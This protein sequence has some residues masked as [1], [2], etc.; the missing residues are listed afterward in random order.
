MR[1]TKLSMP[2]SYSSADRRGVKASFYLTWYTTRE[3]CKLHAVDQRS[4]RMTLESRSHAPGV[5][6]RRIADL[7]D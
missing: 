6:P 7:T 4:W 2:I 1:P 5:R 3:N